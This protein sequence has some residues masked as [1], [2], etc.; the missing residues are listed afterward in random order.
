MIYDTYPTPSL[1]IDEKPSENRRKSAAVIRVLY[2]VHGYVQYVLGRPAA[3]TVLAA[4]RRLTGWVE[5]VGRGVFKSSGKL[6]T[7]YDTVHVHFMSSSIT[8]MA[9]ILYNIKLMIR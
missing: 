6:R 3:N 4:G 5:R 2:C 7:Q 1:K 8:V 9:A